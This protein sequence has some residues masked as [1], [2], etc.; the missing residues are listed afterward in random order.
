MKRQ[1]VLM[2]WDRMGDYHRARWHA[3][4]TLLN[5]RSVFAADLGGGDN[6]Y[7]WSD[8][9]EDMHFKLSHRNPAKFDL[10][11]IRKFIRLLKSKDIGYV[12]IAGYGRPEYILFL[13]YSRLTNRRVLLFAESWYPSSNLVD[14]FKSAFLNW[15]CNAF[16]VSGERAKDHF[17][18]RLKVT[19]QKIRI[20][21]SVVDN[22]HFASSITARPKTVLCI[23][24][25]APEK[26]IETMIRAFLN[27][28]LPGSGWNLMIVGGGQLKETFSKL[29]ID[30]PI[31]LLDWQSYSELPKVYRQACLFVLPSTFE[32]WGLVVNEAMA[33]GLPVVISNEV[34]CAP[35]LLRPTIN[36]W[37]FPATDETSLT[38]IFDALVTASPD[39]VA[40]GQQSR[41]I[42][43]SYSPALFAANLKA[44]LLQ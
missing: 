12:C 1:N 41:S 26:N 35:D 6:L 18:N 28:M 25:F 37:T 3:T 4:R 13:V 19:E 34:G 16:L 30:K 8:T 20:G 36:G 7:S 9:S 5:D 10:G 43:S 23:G 24:R 2:V 27:S 15:C 17:V 29:A 33:A 39:L 14:K 40:M 44:L 38:N 42:I 32:P 11:R 22:A 31:S 21:Y